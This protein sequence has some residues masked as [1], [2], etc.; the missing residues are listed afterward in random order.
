MYDPASANYRFYYLCRRLLAQAPPLPPPVAHRRASVWLG[1][2][3][4]GSAVV[5]L[6]QVAQ[7]WLTARP[8]RGLSANAAPSIPGGTTLKE[9]EPARRSTASLGGGRTTKPDPLL[10]PGAIAQAPS[11][12]T[13]G[14]LPTKAV[15]RLPGLLYRRQGPGSPRRNRR[16]W[17]EPVACPVFLL[18]TALYDLLEQQIALYGLQKEN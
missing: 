16:G 8:L 2:A 14:A 7:P 1:T 5:R 17:V 3:P 11:A 10:R 9:G 4:G 15:R 12:T 18:T 6:Y 13:D